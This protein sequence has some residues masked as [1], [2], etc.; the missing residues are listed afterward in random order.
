MLSPP[1]IL[2]KFWVWLGDFNNR[3]WGDK[4]SIVVS[5]VETILLYTAPKATFILFYI[6]FQKELNSIK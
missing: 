6:S 5:D 4:I 3:H 1:P 2:N